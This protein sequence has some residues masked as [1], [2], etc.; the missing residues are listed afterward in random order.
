LACPLCGGSRCERIDRIRHYQPT[1]IGSVSIDLS[2]L[3]FWLARCPECHFQFST[4][5]IP[6]E[7]LLACYAAT[8]AEHWSIEVNPWERRYDVILD[9][10][11]RNSRGRRVLD[12]GCFT[13]SLLDYLG[14]Q[15]TRFGVEPSVPAAEASRKRGV[16]I[17]GA[18]LDDIPAATEPFD[19]IV[20]VDVL[21]HINEPLPLFEKLRDYLKP[22]GILVLITGDTD[23]PTWRWMKGRYWYCSYAGHVSYFSASTLEHVGRRLG[24]QSA[25]CRR[26]SHSRSRFLRH[27]KLGLFNVSYMMG[28]ALGGLGL[29][30]L[31]RLTVDAPA[32]SWMTAP[33]HLFC[34]MRRVPP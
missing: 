9:L 15:W 27:V 6:P 25:E 31:K 4:P 13:G 17:L 10:L 29:K 14:P 32:P 33:D 19:A 22:D 12:V 16:Q 3:E 21:E 24:F 23:A 26:L 30:R 18:T 1:I 20:S 7:K 11:R 8:N 28:V 2:G 5:R 34:V